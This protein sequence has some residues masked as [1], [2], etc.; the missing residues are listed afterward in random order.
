M[1]S[2]TSE[3]GKAASKMLGVNEIICWRRLSKVAWSPAQE[4]V[5]A[6]NLLDVEHVESALKKK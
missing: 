4:D 2:Q 5:V 1:N 6:D 3:L